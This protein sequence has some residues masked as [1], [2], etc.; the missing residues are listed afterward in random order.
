MPLQTLPTRASG[1]AAATRKVAPSAAMPVWAAFLVTQ[2]YLVVRLL[3]KLAFMASEVVFFQGELAHA[4]YTAAPLPI[5]PESASAE[6]IGNLAQ[7]DNRQGTRRV[8]L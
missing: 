4:G 5:W 6:A 3:A 1:A 8:R 7:R 2:I